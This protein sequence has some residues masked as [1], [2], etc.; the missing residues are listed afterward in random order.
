MASQFTS[1][2]ELLR[3]Q[4]AAAAARM[5]AEDGAD[6]SSAKRKAA[7]QILG[8][9]S[10]QGKYLPDNAQIE[11]EVRIYNELYLADSQPARLALL[12]TL[13]LQLMTELE[14]FDPYLTGA[15]L[16]GTANEHSDIHLQLFVDSPKDVEI[17]LLNKNIDFEVSETRHFQGHKAPVET[18]S[19]FWREAGAH[20]A[21]Y[22]K[23]DL[24]GAVKSAAGKRAERA[25]IA[26]VRTLLAEGE[27]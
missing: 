17:F 22:E 6:Y 11:E 1:D 7:K 18:L 2:T 20:L 14:Q 9:A 19:F 13:A 5:I 23:D 21:L 3:A 16:N 24:R 26:A 15:V 12:R 10:G 8:N 4:I 25:G 27:R